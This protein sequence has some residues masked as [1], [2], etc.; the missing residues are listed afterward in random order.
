[1]S[2]ILKRIFGRSP[3]RVLAGVLAFPRVVR[4]FLSV[5]EFRNPLRALRY[6]LLRKCPPDLY[7]E[8]RSGL[9][10]HLSGDEDDMSTLLVVFGRK[11]Y[12]EIPKNAV[13]IDVGAHLGSFSL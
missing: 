9:R 11:D 12:G 4:S 3:K 1:M 13:V 8:T 7:V 2:L 6:Y 10:I 5:R